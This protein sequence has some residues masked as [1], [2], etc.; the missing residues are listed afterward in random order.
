MVQFSAVRGGRLRQVPNSSRNRVVLTTDCGKRFA[1]TSGGRAMPKNFAPFVILPILFV[2]TC[3]YAQVPHASSDR[4]TW[5][6]NGSVMYLIANGSSREF[7]YEKPRPGMLAAGAKT[8]SLLF[9]GEV[10]N[11]QYSGTAY[12]FNP[13]CGH[14]PFNV[15]GAILDGGERIVLTGPAPRVGRNCQAYASYS[16]TLEFRFLKPLA[17]SPSPEPQN[18]DESKAEVRLTAG[19]TFNSP[20]SP[21][22]AANDV[23][24][25][26]KEV[27]GNIAG[28]A[29]GT[30]LPEHSAKNETVAGDIDNYVSAGSIIVIVGAL[31]FFFARQLS[32]K[33]FWRNRGFY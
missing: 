6:H 1:G 2:N 15:K 17:D 12:I 11:G 9:R 31:L 33:L 23:A 29:F 24:S 30:P 22:P 26:T 27:T 10:S 14:V 18:Q 21:V 5:E 3:A 25:P 20:S 32:R 16:A 28:P 8:G 19:N 4:T 13:Q 7:F